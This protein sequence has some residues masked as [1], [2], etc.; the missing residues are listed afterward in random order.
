MAMFRD[1]ARL[2]GLIRHPHVVSVLDVG[3]DDQGLF[4]AMEYI[5]G[6]SISEALSGLDEG[7]VLP[8]AMCL[9]VAAQA[10]RG[11]HAA[12]ELVDAEGRSLGLVH[13]DV[14]PKNIL[15]GFDGVVRVTDFGIAKVLDRSSQT[16]TGIIKGSIGYVSPEA[17]RFD[18]VDRRSDIFS[19]AV[20][21][22]EMLTN[23]RLHG[24]RDSAET[25]RHIL[26]DPPPDIIAARPEAP[27]ELLELLVE[28]L[29]KDPSQRPSTGAVVAARLEAMVREVAV[30]EG[31]FIEAAFDV[32]AYMEETFADEKERRAQ[33]TRQGLRELISRP[34]TGLASAPPGPA[35]ALVPAL[36]AARRWMGTRRLLSPRVI[37]VAAS[38]IGLAALIYWRAS[39]GHGL[40]GDYFDDGDL[41]HLKFSRIDREIAFDWGVESPDPRLPVD[42]FS[43][44]WTGYISAPATGD[45]DLCLLSDEGPRLWFDGRMVIDKWRLQQ[46]TYECGGVTF[47]AGVKVPIRIEYF[48]HQVG[49]TVRLFWKGKPIG[50]Q[51]FQPVPGAF[52]FPP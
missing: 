26:R 29:A 30:A 15:I 9:T 27:A 11:L 50:G 35:G 37:A 38:T 18:P 25:A 49:A 4:L 24:G 51:H 12:H 41:R 36:P 3:E 2:A 34:Q 39:G 1:E 43:V 21:L 5:E 10:A 47:K 40:R 7:E 6:V 22:Y 14:S 19:L 42:D 23:E 8:L 16:T 13:R 32:S 44:R 28:M 48:E 20:V 52:L 17:L 45:Y 33:V 46:P 31:T